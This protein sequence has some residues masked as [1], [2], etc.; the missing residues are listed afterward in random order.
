MVKMCGSTH[1]MKRTFS[2]KYRECP[3][4]MKPY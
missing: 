4:Y 1:I 3:D 2:S